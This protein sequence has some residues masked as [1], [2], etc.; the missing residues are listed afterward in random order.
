MD[1]LR[2]LSR[3]IPRFNV[4]LCRFTS[5]LCPF[6]CNRIANSLRIAR[7]TTHSLQALSKEHSCRLSTGSSNISES[8]V[9]SVQRK[10]G[11]ILRLAVLSIYVPCISR[12]GI[13]AKKLISTQFPPTQKIKNDLRD[14]KK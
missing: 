2:D 6:L 14:F 11:W 3:V 1:L 7:L 9:E 4:S 10:D 13:D 8:R 5:S 12:N